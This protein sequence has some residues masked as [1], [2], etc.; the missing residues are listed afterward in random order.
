MAD[1]RINLEVRTEVSSV[2]FSLGASLCGP[3][4]TP[5]FRTRRASTNVELGDG[6]VFAIAGLLRDELT[7]TVSMYPFLGHIPILGTLFRS[8]GYRNQLTE[9]VILVRP[10]L[11][12]PLGPEA[13]PLPTDYF[14][15][16]NWFEFYLLGRTEGFDDQYATAPREEEEPQAGLIGDAG[17]RLPASHDDDEENE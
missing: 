12:Q 15:Q 3:T 4:A 16:P 6:Q 17:Y 2:D 13:P 5:G 1:D 11:I 14:D 10:R 9:L 8:S 7:E